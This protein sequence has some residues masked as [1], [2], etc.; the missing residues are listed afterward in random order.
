MGKRKEGGNVIKFDAF[1]EES[2]TSRAICQSCG[3]NILKGQPRVGQFADA[4]RGST[5]IKWRHLSCISI[6][7]VDQ[8]QNSAADMLLMAKSIAKLRYEME[9]ANVTG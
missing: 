9:A 1:E 7:H 3:H 2:T 8:A 4:W 5:W 6:D